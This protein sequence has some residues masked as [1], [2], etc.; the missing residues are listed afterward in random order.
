[1]KKRESLIRAHGGFRNLK[2][3]QVAQLV[4]DV[5]VR[6]CEKYIEIE[7]GQPPTLVCSKKNNTRFFSK[8]YH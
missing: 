1:M 5:T 8:Y 6:F 2:S 7:L 4:F 3:F